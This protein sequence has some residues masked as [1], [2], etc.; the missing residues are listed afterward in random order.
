MGYS[1]IDVDVDE[2]YKPGYRT[3]FAVRI[4]SKLKLYF[5]YNTVIA[6]TYRGVNC[7]DEKRYSNTTARHRNSILRNIPDVIELE[8]ELFESKLNACLKLHNLV[9]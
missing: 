3:A 4:G 7:I 1:N 5:S 9:Y 2:Y 6:F 8:H